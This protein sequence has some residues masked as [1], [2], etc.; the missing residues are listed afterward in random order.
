MGYDPLLAIGPADGHEGELTFEE[1]SDL[2]I[3]GLVGDLVYEVPADGKYLIVLSDSVVSA[4]GYY[5][6]VDDITEEMLTDEDE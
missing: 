1:Y 3:F 5:I 2:N 6:G 4:S